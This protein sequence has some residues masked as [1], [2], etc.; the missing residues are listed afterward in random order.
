MSEKMRSEREG[1]EE[2]AKR[3]EEMEGEESKGEGE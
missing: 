3:T 1:E 2:R